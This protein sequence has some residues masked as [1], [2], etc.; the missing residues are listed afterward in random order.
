M[1][2]WSKKD[3]YQ[4]LMGMTS[5]EEDRILV[6]LIINKMVDKDWN[7]AKIILKSVHNSWSMKVLL[8][9]ALRFFHLSPKYLVSI[10]RGMKRVKCNTC[11]RSKVK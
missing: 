11:F 5:Q 2:M 7:D 8:L 10:R 3:Y 9:S 6:N 4:S 1:G